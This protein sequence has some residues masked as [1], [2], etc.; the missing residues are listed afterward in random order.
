ERYRSLVENA[1][2]ALFVF[3]VEKN[4][5]VDASQSAAR[6]FRMSEEELLTKTP[7]D[8]SPEFQPDGRRSADAAREIIQ[9]VV[10]GKKPFFEWTHRDSTG[11]HIACEVWLALLPGEDSHL[12]R[13]SIIDIS[14]RK[15]AADAIG[16]IQKEIAESEN[17]LRTILDTDPEC[18][19]LLDRE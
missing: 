14:E 4:H 9:S 17:R 3:D 6:L 16:L 2:E 10:E 11:M 5:F 18:I 1:P 8:L 12:I 13:G 7:L 15:K 19:S